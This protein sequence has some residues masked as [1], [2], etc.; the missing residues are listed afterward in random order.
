MPHLRT[1]TLI[2]ICRSFYTHDNE[3]DNNNNTNNE[4]NTTNNN[5]YDNV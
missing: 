5:P 4:D 2:Y 1:P 3:E